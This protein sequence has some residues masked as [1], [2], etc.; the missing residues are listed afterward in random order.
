MHSHTKEDEKAFFS[1]IEDSVSDLC[2]DIINQALKLEE[3]NLLAAKPQPLNI[4]KMLAFLKKNHFSPDSKLLEMHIYPVLYKSIVLEMQ[5]S[6]EQIEEN[7][8]DQLDYYRSLALPVGLLKNRSFFSFLSKN[9]DKSKIYY[10]CLL[11]LAI[12]MSL[13]Q[14]SQKNNDPELLKKVL[15]APGV[16]QYAEQHAGIQYLLEEIQSRRSVLT[17]KLRFQTKKR[18]HGPLVFN[19]LFKDSQKTAS[20]QHI[21]GI[22]QESSIQGLPGEESSASSSTTPR[23][24]AASQTS[25]TSQE[26]LIPRSPRDKSS[27]SSSTA[28]RESTYSHASEISRN[29]PA[30]RLPHRNAS[31]SS[32]VIILDSNSSEDAMP[33]TPI[34]TLTISSPRL[35]TNISSVSFQELDINEHSDITVIPC[36]RD[37]IRSNPADLNIRLK[38]QKELFK[39]RQAI[40]LSNGFP[41]EMIAILSEK[42]S[43]S[44]YIK[45][46]NAKLHLLK[47]IKNSN[48]SDEAETD[49]LEN[50]IKKY[51][52]KKMLAVLTNN[53]IVI[54]D[55]VINNQSIDDKDIESFKL[56][57]K[58]AFDELNIFY[59]RSQ[60]HRKLKSYI[61]KQLNIEKIPPSPASDEKILDAVINRIE[62]ETQKIPGLKDKIKLGLGGIKENTETLPDNL[63]T[64]WKILNVKISAC[65]DHIESCVSRLLTASPFLKNDFAEFMNG[66]KALSAALDALL[67]SCMSSDQKFKF[68]SLIKITIE[69][70]REMNAL[71]SKAKEKNIS[72]IDTDT[73]NKKA[74]EKQLLEL[75]HSIYI[76]NNDYKNFKNEKQIFDGRILHHLKKMEKLGQRMLEKPQSS[77]TTIKPGSTVTQLVRRLSKG[78]LIRGKSKAISG[79]KKF[80][81]L[82][83][84]RLQPE[85]LPSESPPLPPT[86]SQIKKPGDEYLS[87]IHKFMCGCNVNKDNILLAMAPT[88]KEYALFH[89]IATFTN[90]KKQTITTNLNLLRQ[91]IMAAGN[92]L[93]ELMNNVKQYYNQDPQIQ[94]FTPDNDAVIRKMTAYFSTPERFSAYF[95]EYLIMNENL[96]N[97]TSRYKKLLEIEAGNNPDNELQLNTAG[98]V[99]KKM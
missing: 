67:D 62:T 70:K 2:K 96:K 12:S 30:L 56:T 87:Q 91:N 37:Y 50:S 64:L 75:H 57:V 40:Y 39:S 18:D 15:E 17:R 34:R 61:K 90:I 95:K 24:T 59:Q 38:K 28:P 9:P 6:R 5:L 14:I 54:V 43:L 79:R 35:K 65:F 63:D 72:I 1:S 13:K 27:D 66:N 73:E 42:L 25:D 52:R 58:A 85:G 86:S 94:V 23:D 83:V 41:S 19:S 11:Y 36:V 76:F 21:S 51:K 77:E 55:E 16:M 45:K 68:A 29:P 98:S 80:T 4:I 49:A 84:M 93:K 32:N 89:T 10:S 26:T 33:E 81:E 82:P 69:A 53:F 88:E 44:K 74:K 97:Y 47:Q 48:L 78:E 20:T 71:M 22:P 99:H 7:E 8:T 31:H 46:V 92:L 60:E 3:N